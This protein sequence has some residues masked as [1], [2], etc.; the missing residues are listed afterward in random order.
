MFTVDTT[1]GATVS[2]GDTLLVL[3]A[4]KME[5][6]LEAPVGGT[7][8]EIRAEEGQLVDEDEVLVVLD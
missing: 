6:P 8:A 7:V 4:M 3:E 5:S 2:E 1:V